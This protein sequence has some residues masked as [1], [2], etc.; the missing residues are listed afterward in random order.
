[1][2][3]PCFIFAR[4]NSQRLKNKNR[5]KFLNLPL[6]VHTIKYAKDSKYVKNIVVSTDDYEIKCIAEKLNC[7][8]IYP[9]PNK[10]SNDSASSFSALKHAINFYQSN[11]SDFDIYAYLQITEPLRPPKILDKCIE[12]LLKNKKINSSFAAFETKKTFWIQSKNKKFKSFNPTY[13]TSHK[14][15][16]IY[17]ED[18]GVSLVS[19][20]KITLR[21]NKMINKPIKIVPYS[22]YDGLLD[23]HNKKDLKLGE[24]IKKNLIK[25]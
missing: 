3:I 12:K 15:K 20:K 14:K 5:I 24:F 17:R 4:K 2:L 13:N 10:L 21:N 19:R 23:I 25:Y 18:C 1:M 11:I 7:I 9:R 16:I 22:S 6:I 8:T